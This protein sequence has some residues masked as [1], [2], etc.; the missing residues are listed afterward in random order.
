[1]Y[2]SAI[3]SGNVANNTVSSIL[4][5]SI[6]VTFAF[7]LLICAVGIFTDYSTNFFA[8]VNTYVLFFLIVFY[9]FS[10]GVN[11]HFLYFCFCVCFF[12]F[13]MGQKFFV[14]LDGGSYDTFL[15]FKGLQLTKREYFTF[16]NLMYFS[17]LCCFIGYFVS[18]PQQYVV[19][20]KPQSSKLDLDKT[21]A[22]IRVFYIITFICA[23]IMQIEILLAKR[24][25]SYT[26]GYLINVDV[27]P[28]IKIGNYLFLGMAFLY[29]SC[30]PSKKEM[31]A[32]LISFMFVDGFLQLFVGRRALLAQTLFF[33]IWYSI[34]YLKADEKKFT[35]KH[36]AWLCLFAVILIFLFWIV[37]VLRSGSSFSGTS[38]FGIIKNFC[39]S[40]GGSDS[41]IA[42]II[43]YGDDFPKE[44]YVYYFSPIK[45]ALLDNVVSRQI[46]S[47]L[48]GT[49][50]SSV[51]QGLE[52]LS[53]HDSFSHWLSY[54]V[55]PELYLKGYGMGS[56]YIAETYF[57]FGTVGVVL[58]NLILGWLI[59]KLNTFNNDSDRI[60]LKATCLY[61][62]HNLFVLPR[63][64]V[65]STAT[66]FLYFAVALLIIKIISSLACQ[67][68]GSGSDGVTNERV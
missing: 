9:I 22:V 60:Y 1:M 39:I 56:S 5:F 38:F 21:R 62:V 55:N 46:I 4:Q 63:G 18:K 43:H 58:F 3:K 14:V 45:D 17:L 54:T 7:H 64:G 19:K 65:F 42:N 20:N 37:E 61:I 10:V 28:I 31:I 8:Y 57:A 36:F 47:I 6:C 41:T 50:S 44:G 2:N 12:I 32:I 25:M 23:C 15:T 11:K 52:Y 34:C 30:R 33:I 40:T 35:F 27:N 29:L 59:R 48:T 13:L 68:Q 16:I 66:D 53:R 24:G 49:D 67:K 51:A 26:D